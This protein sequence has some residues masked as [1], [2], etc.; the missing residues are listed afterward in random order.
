MVA[1]MARG[2]RRFLDII[3]AHIITTKNVTAPP[4]KH[5]DLS[6]GDYVDDPVEPGKHWDN[7]TYQMVPD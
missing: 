1:S 6:V 5:Y 2:N 4:A 3:K 7:N